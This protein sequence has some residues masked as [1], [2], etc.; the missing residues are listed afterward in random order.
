MKFLAPS[1][2]SKTLVIYYPS[3]QAATLPR[4]P[5]KS[6]E[7]IH[8]RT[9]LR[10]FPAL[11]C[12]IKAKA[13]SGREFSVEPMIHHFTSVKTKNDPERVSALPKAA[14]QTGAE[15]GCLNLKLLTSPLGRTHSHYHPGLTASPRGKGSS[16]SPSIR[17]A[18]VS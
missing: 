6:N 16:L 11:R 5:N 12:S 8:R 14:Q 10:Y 1:S 7:T 15:P 18:E 13:P 17:A 2:P 3:C 9:L 4:K